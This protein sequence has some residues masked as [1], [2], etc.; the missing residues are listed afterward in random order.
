MAEWDHIDENSG[1]WETVLIPVPAPL[2]Q[3]SV[4]ASYTMKNM[5]PGAVYDII[6]K[7]KNKYGWSQMSKVFNF[8]NKG[9]DY[10]TQQL[11]DRSD[12]QQQDYQQQFG[13][14]NDQV[15][16]SVQ[17]GNINGAGHP[18]E[19]SPRGGGGDGTLS[20][21]AASSKASFSVHR[22]CAMAMA[23]NLSSHILVLVVLGLWRTLYYQHHLV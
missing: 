10:S 11:S 13:L 8:F 23:S 6:A 15:M 2:P 7:A 5:N 21:P 14:M 1:N 19:F 3:F 17:T 18:S 9:V 4:K 22:H 20:F 16:D 12:K